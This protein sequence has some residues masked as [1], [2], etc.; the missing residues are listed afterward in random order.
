MKNYKSMKKVELV[1]FLANAEQTLVANKEQELADVV[2][3]A[4]KQYQKNAKSVSKDELVEICDE[5]QPILNNI[6]EDIEVS[7]QKI[8]DIIE[9]KPLPVETSP[10]KPSLGKKKTEPKVEEQ[11]KKEEQPK[12]EEKKKETK[13]EKKKETKTAKKSDKVRELATQFPKELK[14]DGDTV[15]LDLSVSSLEDLRVGIEKGEEYFIA[16]YWTPRLI[17]Q[18]NY[19]EHGFAD[20]KITKFENDL[21]ICQL[22]HIADN[23]KVAY[24]LSLYSNVMYMITPE[25]L[26][27]ID[28]MRYTNG[29]EYNIYKVK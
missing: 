19:D 2:T 4:L 21:D 7:A 6:N 1:E 10:K 22:I 15:E 28:G 29:A 9:G 24:A 25:D 18:F 27:I 26:E 12:V 3:Y 5:V 14:L 17:K 23:H 16:V 8:F 13:E 20:T 11:P